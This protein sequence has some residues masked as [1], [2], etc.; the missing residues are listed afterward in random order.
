MTTLHLQRLVHA[1]P[2][3]IGISVLSFLMIHLIPGDPVQI[4]AGDK[5]LTPERAEELRHEYGLDRPLV[6]QYCGLCQPR[7]ARRPWRRP[8]QPAAGPGQHPGG[9]AQHHPADAGRPAHRRL[10]GI[11]LGIIAAVSHGTLAGHRRHGRRHA[12]H[13]DAHFLFE[14]AADPALFVHPGLVTGH[15]PGRRRTP[16]HARPGAG[17][18]LGRRP[19]PTRAL[20]HAGSPAPGVRHHRPRQG[21]RAASWWSSVTP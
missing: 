15:R 2:V 3:L 18:G 14:P 5:P 13:L 11:S 16:D 7:A 1:I 8:A 17:S 10:L 6:V 19:G 12:G 9:P 20:Q 4:F 21:P